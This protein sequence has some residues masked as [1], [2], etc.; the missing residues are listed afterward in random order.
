[1]EDT[2]V[3]L[4]NVAVLPADLILNAPVLADYWDKQTVSMVQKV[5]RKD[6]PKE[7]TFA[8][9]TWSQKPSWLEQHFFN[10][11]PPQ[12]P[13]LHEAY[14]CVMHLQLTASQKLPIGD[15]TYVAMAYQAIRKTNEVLA[16]NPNNEEAY[17]MMGRAYRLLGRYEAAK[18]PVVGTSLNRL[19]RYYQ[20]LSA[21]SQAVAINP[22]NP[23][24]RL[25][26]YEIQ[27]S[28]GKRDLALQQLEAYHQLTSNRSVLT[29]ND[30]ALKRR[31]K[32]LRDPLEIESKRIDNE[33]QI[34]LKN[35]ASPVVIAERLAHSGY[36]LKAWIC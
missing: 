26:L 35:N 8:R 17:R 28:R 23:Q 22:N 11:R 16:K 29:P 34:G 24:T 21:I 9:S 5:F 3:W 18:F 27:I 33:I 12:S 15:A 1:M 20:T 30:K 25:L 36:I 32:E 13:A 10:E 6:L 4:C 14:H 7:L 2:K 19:R 31:L